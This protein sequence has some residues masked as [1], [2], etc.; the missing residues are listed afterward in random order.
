[1]VDLHTDTPWQVRFKKRKPELKKGHITADNV[2]EGHYAAVVFVIYL[3]DTI[4][5]GKPSPRD[6]DDLIGTIKSIVSA[7]DVFRL[8]GSTAGLE[9]GTPIGAD[10][11]VDVLMSIEN[12]QAFAGDPSQIDRYIEQGVRLVGLVH[13]RDNS[14]AGSATGE[15]AGG[16]TDVGKK[17][18]SRVYERGALVDVSHMSDAAF[19]DLVPIAR[20]Q[21][22]PIVASHSNARA[23]CDNP[24]NLTDEQL[25]LI[26]GS[27]GV[28][29]LNLHRKFVSSTGPKLKHVVDQ[30]LHMIRVA[31]IDHVAIGT[32]F[33]GGL[34]V[35]AL[36]DAAQLPKLADALRQRG[37]SD[38]EIGQLFHGNALRVLGWRK[39]REP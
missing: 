21:G 13:A 20:A 4:H 9:G 1:V 7:N 10:G 32:D 39:S 8:A 27:G 38:Q 11:K 29:G 14:L 2:R 15:S 5:D 34:P 12:A 23:V 30:A 18:A 24:R 28:A 33:D 17:L 22:A 35:S 25:K 36:K 26:A 37:L 19:R 31:G 3:P 16:L 6:V